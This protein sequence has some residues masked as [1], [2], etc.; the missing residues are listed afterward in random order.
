MT[1]EKFKQIKELQDK[2][3]E[4]KRKIKKIDT[5]LRSCG[6]SCNITGVPGFSNIKQEY[7]FIGKEEI[8]KILEL[9]K[10]RIAGELIELEK[11]FFNL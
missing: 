3:E 8:V 4:K 9:D 10:G 1:E 2:I 11:E 6:L 7:L 5:L